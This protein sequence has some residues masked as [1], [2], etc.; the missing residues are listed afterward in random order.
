MGWTAGCL[1]LGQLVKE[2]RLAPRWLSASGALDVSGYTPAVDIAHRLV[3][4]LICTWSRNKLSNA[5]PD[6]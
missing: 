5:C 4:S 6:T 1:S 2:E 3:Q